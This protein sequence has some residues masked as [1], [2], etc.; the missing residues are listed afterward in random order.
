MASTLDPTGAQLAVL[1]G[2]PAHT[3]QNLNHVGDIITSCRKDGVLSSAMGKL[4]NRITK[5]SQTSGVDVEEEAVAIATD[6]PLGQLTFELR[7]LK[8]FS[9]ATPLSPNT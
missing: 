1:S 4:G 6:E 3:C 7:Y 5:S 8:F 9:K 2:E